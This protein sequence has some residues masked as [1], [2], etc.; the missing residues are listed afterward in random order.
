MGL[1]NGLNRVW[2]G[3]DWWDKQE[4]QRQREQFAREDEEERRRRQNQQIPRSIGSAGPMNRSDGATRYNSNQD[5]QELIDGLRKTFLPGTLSKDKPS[6]L[7]T[8]K[9]QQLEQYK[10]EEMQRALEEEKKRTSWLNR[11]FLDRNWDDRAE[12]TAR[13][14]ALTRYMEE[15]N[16]EQDAASRRWMG[17]TKDKLNNMGDGVAPVIKPVVSNTLSAHRVATGMVQGGAG[18]Y[19]LVTPGEGTNRVSQWANK[20]AEGTD[21]LAKDMGVEGAY[22]VG[23]V[24]GEVGT[25]FIPGIG[26]VSKGGKL[27]QMGG[28][29]ATKIGRGNR[30]ITGA[31]EELL[32][33][34][35]LALEARLGNRYIGQQAA[36]GE[37]ISPLDVL[38][39]YGMAVPGALFSSAVRRGVSRGLKEG[40]E[41]G[42]DT[43]TGEVVASTGAG[44]GTDATR[45]AVM[46]ATD[47]RTPPG[48]TITDIP[49]GPAPQQTFPD[50]TPRKPGE[51]SPG[52]TSPTKEVVET[53][54]TPKPD[55]AP[56]ETPPA[57]PE[58]TTPPQVSQPPA[59]PVKPGD[60]QLSK[61]PDLEKQPLET[62]TPET[63]EI[64]VPETPKVD[65]PK[66][67]PDTVKDNKTP[68]QEKSEE[69]VQQSTPATD[70][71]QARVNKLASLR[72]ERE[73][74]KESGMSTKEIDR[75]I[76]A[77]EGNEVK[78]IEDPEADKLVKEADQKQNPVDKT[79][80]DAKAEKV[81]QY[82]DMADKAKTA[83]EKAAWNKMA[84]ALES[85]DLKKMQEA[86]KA[87]K[88]AG[89]TPSEAFTAGKATETKT[90]KVESKTKLSKKPAKTVET[91][92]TVEKPKKAPEAPKS[93]TKLSKTKNERSLYDE[94]NQNL[95]QDGTIK[96]GWLDKQ[97]ADPN[98]DNDEL[99]KVVE[100]VEGKKAPA[101]PDEQK[102]RA[103]RERSKKVSKKTRE[104]AKSEGKTKEAAPELTKE[105]KKQSEK[106]T[107][108]PTVGNA[109][110]AMTKE[111]KIKPTERKYIKEISEINDTEILG[112]TEKFIDD[113]AGMSN[114]ELLLKGKALSARLDDMRKAKTINDDAVFDM[115][116]KIEQSKALTASNAGQVHR[117]VREL[118]SS[119][120]SPVRV[121]KTIEK[122]Q[123]RFEALKLDVKVD[124]AQKK[125]LVDK[126]DE[127][128]KQATE[129]ATQE[130]KMAQ[131]MEELINPKLG[132]RKRAQAE[133]EFDKALKARDE[134]KKAAVK[135]NDEY[136]SAL[137]S[138]EPELKGK[139]KFQ[140]WVYS[141][142]DYVGNYLRMSML[143]SPSGRV[144][145][146]G[147]TGLNVIDQAGWRMLE[148]G[149]GKT[150]GFAGKKGFI[151]SMG[152][153]YS[154]KRGLKEGFSKVGKSFR[155]EATIDEALG[156]KRAYDRSEL[157]DG[158]S[159]YKGT[160]GKAKAPES[161]KWYMKP[162]KFIRAAVQAPTD[163]TYGV[164][165]DTL[166]AE[167]MKAANKAG[168][169]GDAAKSY[170]KMFI[171]MPSDEAAER[172]SQRWLENSAMH[173]NKITDG[174]KKMTD[175]L[176]QVG[177]KGKPGEDM[178]ARA[179]RKTAAK[180]IRT[181][182]IPFVQYMGGATQ[183]MLIRQ[184]PLVNFPTAAKALKQG[185]PQKA[186]EYLAR[187]TWNTAK[188]GALSGAIATGKITISDTDA[189]GKTS[190]NGPYVVVGDTYIPVGSFGVAGGSGL[191]YAK[192]VVDFVNAKAEGN[193]PEMLKSLFSKPYVNILKATGFDNTIT[194]QN[195]VGGVPARVFESTN[196]GDANNQSEEYLIGGII[197]D[198]GT[199]GVPAG[200]RDVDAG[201]TQFVGSYN[202][203][204]EKPDT[205]AAKNPIQKG[206]NQIKSGIPF[207]AN[208]LPRKSGEN[209]RTLGGRVLNANSQSDQ[210]KAAIAEKEQETQNSVKRI[211]EVSSNP[212]LVSL[213]GDEAKAIYDKYDG[214]FDKASDADRKKMW[215]DIY[216]N[217][218]R[219]IDDK[220]WGSYAEVLQ[221]KLDEDWDGLSSSEGAKRNREVTRAKVA[222]EKDADPR[223][224]RLYTGDDAEEGGGISNDEYKKMLQLDKD[225]NPKY[226]DAY[227]PELAYA[228]YELDQAMTKA[229]ASA[230]TRGLDPWTRNKYDEPD[231][232]LGRGKYAKSGGSSG[233]RKMPKGGNPGLLNAKRPT[234]GGK[235]GI[236]YKSVGNHMANVKNSVSTRKA[237][238]KKKISVA[239]GVQL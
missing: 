67:Q 22:K 235:S 32:D 137:R 234:T 152:S 40:A 8:E 238:S 115:L 218:E 212:D 136:S 214:K 27:T 109:F 205:S 73:A 151:S 226:P 154:A 134:A 223:I 68:T 21:Q 51:V 92:K 162:K 84:E 72:A 199:Q 29:V 176:D 71:E 233:G 124:N 60:T 232:V 97:I 208:T 160:P 147:T 34:K 36:Q 53:T 38:L 191:I 24:V 64:I 106:N 13:N 192:N 63:E 190:Y 44:L 7:K 167:G 47:S 101:T 18:F 224:F 173:T 81:Q 39:E 196:T 172:A 43:A 135:A 156:N 150:L 140:D 207:L 175:W 82:R 78:A 195:V 57:G 236:P 139:Q 225:G 178:Y 116:A 45:R 49:D 25:F 174:L 48:S 144:R 52:I 16:W 107:G 1:F 118:Y 119:M 117:V 95:K 204:K 89:K 50:G 141:T 88:D 6:E 146:I 133:K 229:G 105:L 76:R 75:Q 85:G 4:N 10:Q 74:L 143:S 187:G 145:D 164:Y 80:K 142:P 65:E 121:D 122:M 197:G 55:D 94:A 42:I 180:I 120:P 11:T 112:Y 5:G 17:E 20:T 149:L 216:D 12:S 99:A 219:L 41:E 179:A 153:R 123:K 165:T 56:V 114:A 3:L 222:Q 35:N 77:L 168:L 126:L 83:K 19:D 132:K 230:N 23:N 211:S 33:P 193:V 182:T 91:K 46:G 110:K 200:L 228:L 209:A 170:A 215:D 113:A 177:T 194:G 104:E 66:K 87:L 217:K 188:I 210:Q 90:P 159:V 14:R 127:F 130:D 203:T 206:I 2:S 125:D 9:E 221:K 98:V 96:K 93:Q 102:L 186:V 163:V 30:L 100:K 166:W 237:P 111:L 59:V 131:A 201:L 161:N 185:N 79:T 26:W 220:K 129:I 103:E 37:D 213:M 31:A 183:A 157:K 231:K 227:N 169:K 202:P 58:T 69:V 108:S 62:K 28:K 181:T 184:N 155:G 15:N 61:A 148:A 138:H 239:R 189:D 171:E 70:I 158:I 86:N 54:P 128:D 198:L